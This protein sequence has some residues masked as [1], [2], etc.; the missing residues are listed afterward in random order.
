MDRLWSPWRSQYIQSIDTV[1]EEEGC[2]FCKALRSCDDDAHYIVKRHTHCAT[3]LNLYPYNSGH[4]LIVP[5][6][7]T[8][9]LLTLDAL[10]YGEMMDL[11]RVWIRI[12]GDVMRPQGF[13][14]GTN[15]GRAAGAG[16]DHHVHLHI[17][18]RWS[19]DVNFMPV[20]GD[21]KIISESMSDTMHRLRERYDAVMERS[22]AAKPE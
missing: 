19:G 6:D 7:H 10:A 22:T 21:T 18:P 14:I 8:D 1:E 4:L 3:F 15:L 9:S 20:I 16:I 11:V 5:Y 13:N 2:V 12:L 17:V